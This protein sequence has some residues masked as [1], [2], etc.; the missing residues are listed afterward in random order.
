MMFKAIVRF[1]KSHW[2]YAGVKMINH[3]KKVG[4][5]SR[6][7]RE[8]IKRIRSTTILLGSGDRTLAEKGYQIQRYMNIEKGIV[9]FW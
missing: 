9:G 2:F 7:E 1:W 3:T 4:K 6:R 8:E 5:M